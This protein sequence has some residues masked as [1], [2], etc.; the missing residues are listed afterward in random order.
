MKASLMRSEYL[1]PQPSR[2]QF[3]GWDN[4][5]AHGDDWLRG[6][7]PISSFRAVIVA[8]EFDR[9][10]SYEGS[11][12][13]P[14][15]VKSSWKSTASIQWRYLDQSVKPKNFSNELQAKVKTKASYSNLFPPGDVTSIVQNIICFNSRHLPR[16]CWSALSLSQVSYY[17]QTQPVKAKFKI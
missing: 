4:N 1:H 11:L 13:N 2:F 6:L 14:K 16:R 9:W 3:F 15:L 8:K 17:R 7:Q 10:I 5:Q 12:A